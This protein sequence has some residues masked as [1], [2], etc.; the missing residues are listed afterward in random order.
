[1]V[2]TTRMDIKN[3][4]CPAHGRHVS[5]CKISPSYDAAFRRR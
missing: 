4:T 5:A 1:M 2:T 3:S